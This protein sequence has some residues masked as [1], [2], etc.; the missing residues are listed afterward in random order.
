MEDIELIWVGTHSKSLGNTY[1][2]DLS[3]Q[4]LMEN[5]KCTERPEETTVKQI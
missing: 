5:A 1:L 2:S 3:S 4:N